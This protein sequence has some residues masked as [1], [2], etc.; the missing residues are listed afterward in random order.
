MTA[1]SLHQIGVQLSQM[2]HVHDPQTTGGHDI[3]STTKWER[4]PDEWARSVP[5]P[6]MFIETHFVF[7]DQY[8][9]GID[10]IVGYW[11]ENRILGGVALFDHSQSWDGDNE[12]NVYFQCTRR[13]VTFRVCQLL[14]D[15]QSALLSFLQADGEDTMRS[16]PFPILPGSDNRV[17]IDPEDAIPI[18][19]VY[20]DIWERPPPRKLTRMEEFGRGCERRSQLDYPEIDVDAEIQEIQRIWENGD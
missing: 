14:D 6:T 19:Q 12:P 13:R 1:C 4:P 8:P 17:R 3:E 7:H 10:D 20:R 9:N 2:E 18:H 11:A 16:C 5:W 15:Q